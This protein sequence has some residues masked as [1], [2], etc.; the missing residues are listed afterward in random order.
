[1]GGAFWAFGVGL[2]LHFT[3][4][5][6]SDRTVV[7]SKVESQALQASVGFQEWVLEAVVGETSV[8]N[9]N[10]STRPS[11]FCHSKQGS[12]APDWTV[13]FSN[14]G[15]L[16]LPILH[17][18]AASSC[19]SLYTMQETLETSTDDK[20]I[21]KPQSKR[22]ESA[23][24]QARAEGTQF[25]RRS[26]PRG[27]RRRA[28]GGDLS[29]A[30]SM[31]GELATCPSSGSR[32]HRSSAAK[33]E[34][35]QDQHCGGSCGQQVFQPSGSVGARV[36]GPSTGFEE[37]LRGLT[38]R[39]RVPDANPG[40]E[41]GQDPDSWPY[42]QTWQTPT[43]VDQFGH[44]NFRVRPQLEGVHRQSDDKV[45]KS[46][47]NVSTVPF[48][49]GPR[50]SE[51][52]PGNSVGQAGST[53]C[54]RGLVSGSTS[55]ASSSSRRVGCRFD[56]RAGTTGRRLHGCGR[57][58]R[59]GRPG[60]TCRV[61]P[62]KGQTNDPS[63]QSPQG[64][65]AHQSACRP[66]EE[67]TQGPWDVNPLCWRAFSSVRHEYTCD[68]KSLRDHGCM[69]GECMTVDE[70]PCQLDRWC[71]DSQLCTTVL[72]NEIDPEAFRQFVEDGPVVA[73][74][75]RVE[76]SPVVEVHYFEED[77]CIG[78]SHNEKKSLPF[79][80]I[81]D[82]QD[83]SQHGSQSKHWRTECAL[84]VN[85]GPQNTPKLDPLTPPFLA[86]KGGVKNAMSQERPCRNLIRSPPN[87]IHWDA[88][89]FWTECCQNMNQVEMQWD[90]SKICD[91]DK[92]A[93]TCLVTTDEPASSSTHRSLPAQLEEFDSAGDSAS[94]L[95][96]A[97]RK[98]LLEQEIVFSLDQSHVIVL[99][100]NGLDCIQDNNSRSQFQLLSQFATDHYDQF[101]VPQAW[102]P[103]GNVTIG[104]HTCPIWS[105]GVAERSLSQSVIIAEFV[106]RDA[107]GLILSHT[108]GTLL[109]SSTAHWQSLDCTVQKI[110]GDRLV[111]VDK[112]VAK[113]RSWLPGQLATFEHGEFYTMWCTASDESQPCGGSFG[114]P[115]RVQTQVPQLCSI[116]GLEGERIDMNI[117]PTQAAA[118]V[119]EMAGG[120]G[121]SFV[122]HPQQS[123]HQQVAV[124]HWDC[125]VPDN[126]AIQVALLGTWLEGH[127]VLWKPVLINGGLC[128]PDEEWDD[129]GAVLKN[130][131]WVEEWTTGIEA[132]PGDCILWFAPSGSTGACVCPGEAPCQSD[133]WCA[134]P[135]KDTV[136]FG[137]DCVKK[138]CSWMD[139]RLPV[140]SK[141]VKSVG[142][143]SN[144]SVVSST[145][146]VQI[147]LEASLPCGHCRPSP[148]G[149]RVQVYD[150]FWKELTQPDQIRL[151][152][153]P[154]GVQLHSATAKALF[155]CRPCH[156][157][158]KSWIYIDGS[159]NDL[160]AGWAVVVLNEGS[161]GEIEFVG[162]LCGAVCTNDVSEAWMGARQATN[163]D[164]EL[165]A[166]IVAQITAIAALQGSTV[167]IRPDLQFS[168]QL[169]T[170]SVGARKD[171]VLAGSV[172]G[173]GSITAPFVEVHEVRGHT[174]DPWNELA[175]RLA[176][177][178]LALGSNHGTFPVHLARR[179]A[180]SKLLRE[181]LW[182][183]SATA[184]HKAA[185]PVECQEGQWG[186]TPCN[187]RMS[188]TLLA[189]PVL[190]DHA[191]QIGLSVAS[192][193]VCSARDKERASNKTRGARAARLD[194]QLHADHIVIAGLQ[195]TRMPQ[196][197]RTTQHYS[198]FASGCQ[199]CGKSVHFGTEIW[200]SKAIAVA[201]DQDGQPVYLGRE[202]P[203]V[204]HA[205]PRRLILR[206][207]G[208]FKATIIAAHAPCL[209]EHNSADEVEAWWQQFLRICQDVDVSTG[210]ICCID[211][212]APLASHS[213][214]LYGLAGA[215]RTNK[216]TRWFQAFLDSARFAVP[217]TLG[218]HVGDQHTWIHPKGAKLRRDYV[219][220]SEKWLPLVS[221]SRTIQ[222]FDTGLFHVD[223]APAVLDIAGVIFGPPKGKHLIDV[224]LVQ[225]ALHQQRFQEALHTL[226]MPTW[227][228]N[229]DQHGDI[230]QTQVMQ[231]AQQVFQPSR[232]RQRER[233][234]LQEATINFIQ[235]KRQVLQMIRGAAHDEA[236]SLVEQLRSIEKE[237]RKQ[238]Q[239]DQQQWYDD[240]VRGI[241]ASGEV[242][243]HKQV[244]RKLIRL[245]RKRSGMP[246]QRP[247]PMLKTTDGR[248]AKDFPEVQ[249]IFCQQFAELEAGIKVSATALEELN[250]VPPPLLQS[251]LDVDFIPSLW[252]LQRT[253]MRFKSGK[254]PGRSGLTVELFRAG[255]V[256]MLHHFL[257]IMVKSVLTV[258]EPLSWKGGRLFAL[259]KGK[260]DPGD[261]GSF[262]SIFLSE[263]AAKMLH[264][265]VRTRLETCWEKQIQEIQH[266]GRK[267]HSTDTAHHIVQAHMAWTRDRK[268]SSAVVFLDLKA[269]FYSVF[270]QSLIGGKWKS[271]DMAF[272][273]S[274]LD[275]AAEDWD[276]L[277]HTTENDNATM[278]LGDHAKRML[279]DMFTATFF[280]M[281]TV[282]DKIA[283]ARGTRPGDPVGDILF[284]ML[285]RL[286]LQDVRQDLQ[287]HPD[288]VWIGAHKSDTDIFH[289]ATLPTTAFAEI[290]FVDDVAYVVHAPTPGQTV[291][292]VQHILSA[293]KDAAAKRGLRVNFAEGKTEVLVNLVGPG[294]RAFRS[295]LW[296]TMNGRIPVV[297]E[298]ETC[299]VQAVHHYKH[300][301]SFL[302]E[303]AISNKDKA[304]RIADAR[305]A[306]G[307]L[308]RPFF[309]KPFL[310]LETKAPVF[311]ALVSSRHLYNVHTWSWVSD[312]E[313]HKWAAGLK[314]MVRRMLGFSSAD[315]PW[316]HMTTEDLYA[317]AGLDA[318]MDALHAARLR[319]VKRAILVA[320]PVLWQLLWQTN[321]PNSWMVHMMKS[322]Q[323]FHM[324]YP[325]M[326][327]E[328]PTD[329]R[330]WLTLV[331][332][333]QGWKGRIKTAMKAC[334]QFRLRQ[335]EGRKW[336]M[337]VMG[338]LRTLGGGRGRSFSP[339]STRMALRSLQSVLP[340]QKGPCYAC[341][342]G[343]WLQTGCQV[344][345]LRP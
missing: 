336:T 31:G 314:D 117:D 118:S 225:S 235:F 270:R 179:L 55:R 205:D 267:A 90:A 111:H 259:Y 335:A 6:A 182:W 287:S 85:G 243:D 15:K 84:D 137:P 207:H 147:S 308:V 12:K 244:F 178:A 99:H 240:W 329:L 210:V 193:N 56:V 246:A 307:S 62:R 201:T 172:A 170:L 25:E 311:A 140:R 327:H 157:V 288:A 184:T 276:D 129:A 7:A 145:P 169:A 264:A 251:E 16:D 101:D 33:L 286:V 317:L 322:F 57:H 2:I 131:C 108:I 88:D 232:K 236:G 47:T 222:G 65:I 180:S 345:C 334:R 294:S 333:D 219:L 48:G 78:N 136:S 75:N 248:M 277:I 291:R 228:L 87:L 272:L 325:H 92:E 120:C 343:T 181:W 196:G 233:P 66:F 328:P 271:E 302:Q 297:T 72:P 119:H 227:S 152:P 313:L 321:S 175:D 61:D 102:T 8:E 121:W 34:R 206:F 22:E 202:R 176:K 278:F 95:Q 69:S 70:V 53:K 150:D 177:Y 211:A 173:L 309:A 247:L 32:S 238:V 339:K 303:K 166:M 295:Q 203:T 68:A 20:Q 310:K 76:F 143:S 260:G 312:E 185:F 123:P 116:L 124:V 241:Q 220:I 189:P 165:Q 115:P 213:T 46:S 83:T 168:H 153:I 242:H 139:A 256:P 223:H 273:L 67:V 127:P 122:S 330:G 306:A 138:F 214:C 151:V 281:A 113:G 261:A 91:Q 163:I 183:G 200:V 253:L 315:V 58:G 174:G 100:S 301:G 192:I 324:H 230:V 216:Q 10:V 249:E 282:E 4:G 43:A 103:L 42:Q 36:A 141:F 292:L 142:G 21:A 258:H 234:Q 9:C 342:S 280:E 212:N 146:R 128:A 125:V 304:C 5:G 11:R 107:I 44:Q 221:C 319:Y 204:L 250:V 134:D 197:Q 300:L 263:L 299:V 199:Q 26:T 237:V 320:P 14:Y 126:V 305:K 160:S 245:G 217:A 262:R 190:E 96:K 266:G 93:D 194:Q 35:G 198:V 73:N 341:Q 98:V 254:A 191:F 112:I 154:D 94:L 275:V 97:V 257:P 74:S 45:C 63:I 51:E 284:N 316:Y 29:A 164:A 149:A 106:V 326:V 209:S 82:F 27:R 59:C 60:R 86:K 252:Q 52:E 1:M 289:D 188:E 171:D 38:R 71:T 268:T 323:W 23:A 331:A 3:A 186:I 30:S 13:S 274:K 283:T 130:G 224:E 135:G 28:G 37:S 17:H 64:H 40:G 158:V 80:D 338:H 156:K 24:T 39:A 89:R 332:V 337:S 318:P 50:I 41:D 340:N 133:R 159:A 218:C 105:C 79:I 49:N 161:L 215:E 155:H 226:P 293:F 81:D 109:L 229:V 104:N 279:Q 114:V 231:I 19:D 167:V 255:G 54:F 195:E 162:C 296:H 239:K 269:A 132:V 148:Q 77:S 187:D 265:M 110:W 144:D 290:A 208:S 344:F 18:S 285:F 298:S